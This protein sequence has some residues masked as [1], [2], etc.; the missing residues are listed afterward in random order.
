[1]WLSRLQ[2]MVLKTMLVFLALAVPSS[3]EERL[4]PVDRVLLGIH[5]QQVLHWQPLP[6]FPA[7][8]PLEQA[9]V[10]HLGGS[11]FLLKADFREEPNF[12]LADLKIYIGL[13]QPDADQT[14]LSVIRLSMSNYSITA[15]NGAPDPGAVRVVQLGKSLWIAYD[16]PGEIQ[17]ATAQLTLRLVYTPF[18]QA[19][20]YRWGVPSP[21]K[22]ALEAS[23]PR[24]VSPP[25]TTLILPARAYRLIEGRDPK[26]ERAFQAVLGTAYE[27]DSNK[28]IRR[29]QLPPPRPMT[30]GRPFPGLKPNLPPSAHAL[31]GKLAAEEITFGI[32]HPARGAT[33][34]QPVQV[35]IP[36]P[37]GGC[38][39]TDHL[40][41]YQG[42]HAVIFS[43]AARSRWEDGSIRWLALDLTLPPSRDA[44]KLSFLS[45]KAA[46]E[47]EEVQVLREGE[48]MTIVTGPLQ[49][50]LH[51]DRFYPL[52]EVKMDGRGIPLARRGMEMQDETGEIHSTL[53]ARPLILEIEEQTAALVVV[54]AEGRLTSAQGK[55]GMSYSA[56]FFFRAGSPLVEMEWRTLNT[57]LERE[58]S[59]FR[60]LRWPVLETAGIEAVSYANGYGAVQE[61]KSPLNLL[62]WSDLEAKTGGE[63]RKA[64]LE[65]AF[66]VAYQGGAIGIV[67]RDFWQR[68]PKGLEVGP[69]GVVME[70]LPPLSQ[71][72]PDLPFYVAFPYLKDRYRMKWGMAFTERM[73]IDFSGTV[74]VKDLI[75]MAQVHPVPLLN[76]QWMAATEAARVSAKDSPLER[77]WDGYF[78]T[79]FERHQER[80]KHQRTYGF[81]NYG[82]WFGERGRNWGNNEYDT[83][84]AF[85]QQYLRTANPRYFRSALAAARHQA[86]VDIIHAYPDP[87]YVGG[88]YIHGI[89]HTGT[90]SHHPRHGVW[91][92]EYGAGAWAWNGH[93]WSEGM[94][95]AWLLAGDRPVADSAL[96]LGEHLRWAVAPHFEPIPSSPRHIGWSI[97][98]ACD[99]YETFG[100]QE[101]LAAARLFAEKAGDGQG[102]HGG[103]L[104]KL[105]G[106]P[107]GNSIFMHGILLSGLSRYHEITSDPAVLKIMQ[108]IADFMNR[109]WDG[110][111]PYM[112]TAEGKPHPKRENHPTPELNLI[113]AEGLAYLGAKEGDAR[114]A[115]TSRA[116]AMEQL[117][118]DPP[119]ASGQKVGNS[120]RSGVETFYWLDRVPSTSRRVE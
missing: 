34:F 38:F 28:G 81:L 106:G 51:P 120:L 53:G 78:A 68:Y 95:A 61:A 101:Y 73:L 76:P 70:L 9:W 32:D 43:A 37:K 21:L 103:Y 77:Q 1:M 108:K 75:S 55:E 67:L 31:K 24:K 13:P 42:E 90:T 11:R 112:V 119:N 2:E 47:T 116:A 14:V 114:S 46:K 60:S 4:Q 33:T 50:S 48:G 26:D 41:L 15:P 84:H 45:K 74:A 3:A 39:Q 59:D 115:R 82:D 65:G 44:F 25:K 94:S 35:G 40:A 54:R 102:E 69:E 100:D 66:R 10:T 80:Q 96:R 85:F 19:E 105:Y 91:S 56:R 92:Q 117:H 12:Q 20:P 49:V 57:L 64:R 104:F 16:A 87:F 99:L 52:A 71:P 83:A 36:L 72:P 23:L 7:T 89:A 111:W 97:R 62:Q 88:N 118:A 86:D 22:V 29:D 8:A 63:R 6:S 30:I 93:S 58:F 79:L 17:A 110:S 109:A 5:P 27:A 113:S 18:Y 107:E 98:L